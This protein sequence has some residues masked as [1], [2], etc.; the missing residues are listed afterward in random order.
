MTD[1][2]DVIVVGGGPGGATAAKC[3][4]RSGFRVLLLE[5]GAR[6]RHKSCG[7][8]LPLV[9]PDIIEQIV[10]S[11]I[12]PDVMSDPP[13]LGLTYIP[14]SGRIN[15]GRLTG[16]TVHNIDRDKFDMWMVDLARDAGAEVLFST[17][18]TSLRQDDGIS[19]RVESK[20]RHTSFRTRFLIGADGVRSTVRKCLFPDLRSSVMVV[21]QEAWYGTG[22]FSN[23]FYGLF[24]GSISPAYSYVIPKDG[25]LIIGT[26]ILPKS[27]PSVADALR[28][29]RTWLEEEFV[30]VGTRLVGRE[31][32]AIPFGKIVHGKGNAVLVGDAAGLCNPLSGE[33][34]RLAVESSEVASI[35]IEK[36]FDDKRVLDEYVRGTSDLSA[37]VRELHEFVV[38]ANDA[39]REEFVRIE[40]T[41]RR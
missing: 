27:E 34:I 18:F 19:V 26:G 29:L 4:A 38:N 5:K 11:S 33:G 36:H 40:L 28:L 31:R 24:K 35:S 37:M 17:R 16:Y 12:P 21:G 14:P 2:Y 3:C 10:Q 9:A 20:G 23:D 7:G 30:F 41:R 39:T 1:N 25:R 13:Q 22:D 15:G 8:V 6:G 32:G